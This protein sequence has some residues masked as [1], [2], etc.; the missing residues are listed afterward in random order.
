[1]AIFFERSV[2]KDGKKEFKVYKLKR[3][4]LWIGCFITAFL[5][6]FLSGLLTI[7]FPH[8]PF[9]IDINIISFIGGIIILLLTL[10]IGG[11]EG[12]LFAGDTRIALMRGK[13]V[14]IKGKMFSKKDPSERWIEK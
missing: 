10:I 5:L 7:Y 3:P 14:R 11:I 8:S 9:L 2:K 4:F 13:E 6:I 1:M 12:N